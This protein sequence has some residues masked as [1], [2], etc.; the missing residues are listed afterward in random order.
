MTVTSLLIFLLIGAVANAR[1]ALF[2]AMIADVPFV[3]VLNT[4]LDD[5]LPLTAIEWDEWGNPGEEQGYRWIRSY[6]PYDNVGDRA[7]PHMLVL[8]GWND[9]RVGYWEAA[10]WVARLRDHNT[11]SG[12]ILLWTNMD[13]GHLGASG[14]FEYLHE[15]ALE[16]AFLID[17]LGL[18]EA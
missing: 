2:T 13:A 5:S 16:Y 15:L 17:R 7:Y 1:P 18:S 9:P 11:G 14:R 8:A 6:S 12:E 10:K 3:D 4:M